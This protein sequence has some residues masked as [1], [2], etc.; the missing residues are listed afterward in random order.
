[1]GPDVVQGADVRVV[2]RGDEPRLAR[3]PLAGRGVDDARPGDDLD[4]DRALEARVAGAVDRA[5]AAG[6]DLAGDLVR[7]QALTGNQLRRWRDV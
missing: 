7:P 4:R 1:M 2:Q 6:A 5:H 3:E